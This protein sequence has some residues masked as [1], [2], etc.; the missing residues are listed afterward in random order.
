ME[1]GEVCLIGYKHAKRLV[2]GAGNMRRGEDD[3]R[4]MW[5]RR[6]C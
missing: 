2:E 5:R 1:F 6:G 4:L 3:T